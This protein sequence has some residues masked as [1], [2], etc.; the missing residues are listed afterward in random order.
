MIS[1]AAGAVLYAKPVRGINPDVLVD[2]LGIELGERNA[3]TE[4]PA[5]FPSDKL[6]THIAAKH[7]RFLRSELP[8]LHTMAEKVAL[9]HAGKSPSLHEVFRV[10][11]FMEEELTSHLLKEEEILFPAIL[12]LHQG[13][14]FP[15][16]LDGPISC[17]IHEHEEAGIALSKLR[18][19]TCDFQ[20]PADACNTYRALLAGLA[21]LEEDLHRHIH[22][23]NSVLFPQ[24]QAM[25]RGN[26]D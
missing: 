9:V 19:L 15:L 3:T 16:S 26:F 13:R 11:C 4:N 20:P 14:S 25:V 6:I 24:A 17:M 21:E 5:T 22:L 18:E 1:A 8:R 12:R 23:E 2:Q 7:H 10:F